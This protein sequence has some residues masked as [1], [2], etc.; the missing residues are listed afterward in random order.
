M[1]EYTASEELENSRRYWLAETKRL[2]EKLGKCRQKLT[3]AAVQRNLARTAR[4]GKED[5]LVY[6]RAEITRIQEERVDAQSDAS[7]HEALYDELKE[8]T[9]EWK[10]RAEVAESRLK[11]CET[12]WDVMHAERDAALKMSEIMPC[13]HPRACL[14]GNDNMRDCTGR[15]AWCADLAREHV[16]QNRL[17]LEIDQAQTETSLLL[18]QQ[19]DRLEKSLAADWERE[20]LR[21]ERAE[22]AEI[23]L[24]RAQ[25]KLKLNATMLS[26]QC[27][28]ARDAENETAEMRTELAHRDALIRRLETELARER[29]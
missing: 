20:R 19:Q 14:V 10:H 15:C 6:L 23:E 28:L 22:R 27:D 7:F 9:D 5:K 16:I 18:R 24:G 21:A 26:H 1:Q 29:A 8:F 11:K 25:G 2:E 12:M 4:D 3:C 13:G 17:R